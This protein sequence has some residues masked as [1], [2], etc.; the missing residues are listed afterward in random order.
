MNKILKLALRNLTR[1]KRRNAI[2]AIAIAFGFFVVTMIDGLTTGM[3]GN[4]EDMVTQVA[5]GTVLIGGYEK[6]PPELEGQKGTVVNIV[7]DKDYIKNL[8]EK[9]DI[10]Y[11]YFSRFTKAAGQMIFNGRKSLT[12]VY[13][14]DFSEKEFLNS[15]QIV[16][17][18]IENL[19][20]PDA[21]IINSKIADNLNLQVGDEIILTTRT[22]YGQNNVADFKIALITKA[23]TLVDSTQVFVNIETLNE[24]VGIPEGGY[25]TF[26]I[27]LNDKT[28]QEKVA[29]KIEA[30]IRADNILVSDRHLAIRNNPSNP[31]KEINKQFISADQQWEGVKY[32][33]ECLE[34]AVPMIKTVLNVVHTITTTILLVI[35]LIVMVGVSNTYRMVLY[36]RIR[37]IGTM[38]ALGMSGKDTGKVFTFEA[39]ILCILGALAGLLLAVIVMTIIHLIPVGN[40]SLAFFLQKG[41]FSFTLSPVSIIVQ[42]LLLIILTTLAVHGSAKKASRMSP[43]EALRTVK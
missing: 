19:S 37:E 17:G 30:L 22:V 12:Q 10:D 28:Q 15:F 13:G 42:Y 36:E 5:G 20:S 7:R 39:I 14:R 40:E 24:I 18:S 3:V 9:N 31:G 29:D 11:K 23:S 1:Q 34:D 2:L 35:L 32:G 16:D 8:V 4:L 38:R 25:S 43:A 33:V 6:I 41:H 26:T 27:F 21:M